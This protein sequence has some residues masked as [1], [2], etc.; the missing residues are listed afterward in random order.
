MLLSSGGAWCFATL[1]KLQQMVGII[2]GLA[3]QAKRQ[4]KVE[5]DVTVQPNQDV[6]KRGCCCDRI[7]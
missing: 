7:V 6:F 1:L 2:D 3:K 4:Q 5:D